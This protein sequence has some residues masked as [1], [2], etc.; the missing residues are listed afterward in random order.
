MRIGV[1]GLGRSGYNIHCQ[2]LATISD[3]FTIAAV[4]DPN[5]ERCA[6]AREAYGCAVYAGVDE[7]IADPSLEVVAVASPNLLHEEQACAA[8]EAGKH[9]VVEKPLS[10]S[11]EG[12]D[13]MIACA[14]SA[15]RVLAPFQNRRFEAHLRKVREVIDSGVLGRIIQIRIDWSGFTR[16]WDWQTLRSRGGGNLHNHGVHLLD[17]A[18]ELFGE[19]TPEVFID[20]Q[21]ALTLG[22]A[23]DHVKL[24]L[25]GEGRPTIDIESSSC[26]AYPMKR[27][28]VWGTAGG[29]VGTDRELEWRY[30]D[31]ST[32]P[33]RAVDDGPAEG[34]VYQNEV[35]DWQTGR[36][37]DPKTDP[38]V[39]VLFYLNLYEVLRNGAELVVTPESVRR[40]MHVLDQCHEQMGI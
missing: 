34:R 25:R 11:T 13:R 21:R 30:V 24:I 5:A 9:A 14:G 18:L 26:C 33:E 19:G 37:E 39:A 12:A 2:N 32:M 28:H 10:L 38:D 40:Q 17:H 22:D 4:S 36:W 20:T 1:I 3:H 27:W 7:L 6:E 15:G 31:W 29:L 35:Y 8:M 16:R 23:E